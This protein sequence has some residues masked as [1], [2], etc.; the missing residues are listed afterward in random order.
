MPLSWLKLIRQQNDELWRIL[1]KACIRAVIRSFLRR[2][3]RN[4]T[5]RPVK[6]EPHLF[7]YGIRGDIVTESHATLDTKT[8]FTRREI[9]ANIHQF[10][11]FFS[12]IIG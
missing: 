12:C 11:C 3:M 4:Q 9:Y 1:E 2:S 5:W 10:S 6:L 8:K 7:C